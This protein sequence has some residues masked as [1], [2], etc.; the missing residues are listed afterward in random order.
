MLEPQSMDL[1]IYYTVLLS[2]IHCHIDKSIIIRRN[3]YE[4]LYK[5]N[6]DP[7]FWMPLTSSAHLMEKKQLHKGR[8]SWIKLTFLNVCLYC[9]NKERDQHKQG[10]HMIS[11][12]SSIHPFANSGLIWLSVLDIILLIKKADIYSTDST[13]KVW[14]YNNIHPTSSNGK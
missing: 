5:S 9:N 1:S 3:G 13:Y 11:G 4:L 12:S 7:N 6:Y 10:K 8:S 14:I 2:F